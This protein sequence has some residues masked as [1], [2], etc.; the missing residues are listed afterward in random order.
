[1]S[2]LK[3]AETVASRGHNLVCIAPPSASAARAVLGGILEP[4]EL[5]K[6][7]QLALAP[8]EAVEEWAR[9]AARV[10]QLQAGA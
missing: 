1:M 9:V 6:R 2:D 10:K 7:L 5:A 8:P 3:L 4:G